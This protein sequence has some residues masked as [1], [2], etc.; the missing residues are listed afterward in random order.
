MRVLDKFEDSSQF[1]IITHNKGTVMVSNCLLGVTQQEAGVSKM[2]GY[3][4]EDIEDLEKEHD[5]LK[6]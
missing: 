1:I 6:G 4:L 5:T 3:K 2:I